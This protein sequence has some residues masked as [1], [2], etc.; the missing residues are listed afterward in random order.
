MNDNT[1]L[2]SAMIRAARAAGGRI[3]HYFRP[4][5]E[6]SAAAEITQKSH[7]HPLTRADTEANEVI[8]QTLMSETPDYGWLSEETI[9]SVDRL[10]KKRIWIVDPLDGTKEFIRGVPEFAVSIALV[11]DGLPIL[12]CLFNPA[13]DELFTAIAGKGSRKNDMPIQTTR[14]THLAGAACLASRSETERGDWASFKDEFALRTT[15]SIAYKLS[16]LAEGRADLTFTLTPK[17]EWDIAA[18]DLLVRE[19]H[20]QVTDKDG[21]R[22]VFNQTL[23]RLSAVLATNGQLHPALLRRLMAMP[24]NRDRC[25]NP[26]V[27]PCQPD[28]K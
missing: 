15:G 17:N 19:A 23:P 20:G 5:A 9:D 13:K 1:Q 14:T 24:L 2:L 4:G 18:G 7:D 25:R 16:L 8:Q 11:E 6:V 10:A 22:L 28:G 12:A 3:M 27:T 26:D 21:A